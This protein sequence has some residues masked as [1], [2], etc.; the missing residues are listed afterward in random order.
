MSIV[1]IVDLAN[2]VRRTFEGI[3]NHASDG[4]LQAV[5]DDTVAR[6]VGKLMRV[7]HD[8]HATHAIFALEGE[9]S[10]NWRRQ[11]HAGY[12]QSR[13]APPEAYERAIARVEARLRENGYTCV[14][15]A[16]CEADDIIA[17]IATRLE[18]HG[19]DTIIVSTDK[20][21]YCLLSE[22]TIIY[23][24]AP[25]PSFRDSDWFAESFQD[26]PLALYAELQ[27]LTGDKTD[28]I[29]GI[30]GIGIKRG[31]GLLKQFGSLDELV[32]RAHEVPGKI[33]EKLRQG[34]DVLPLSRRLVALRRDLQLGLNLA[35]ARLV[36]DEAT[37]PPARP[38][39]LAP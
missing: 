20:D 13:E 11:I 18:G 7:L 24:H 22:T 16:E 17:S 4:D 29:P 38:R 9:P 25:P 3:R 27:A 8:V 2:V 1:A 34:L 35:A 37:A 12:K 36:P 33:G 28:D 5:E 23:H 21:L 26:L 31:V 19:V 10:E 30:D 39:S 6:A 32:A 15:S 14:G